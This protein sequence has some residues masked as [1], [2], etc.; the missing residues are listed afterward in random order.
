M[1]GTPEPG[2]PDLAEQLADQAAQKLTSDRSA[3]IQLLLAAHVVAPDRAVYRIELAQQLLGPAQSH[4]VLREQL[5]V[6]GPITYAAYNASG[7]FL[8]TSTTSKAYVWETHWFDGEWKTSGRPAREVDPVTAAAIGGASA[9]NMMVAT[10]SNRLATMW[11]LT[12]PRSVKP[13]GDLE[14]HAD[15]VAVTTTSEIAATVDGTTAT[16]WRAVTRPM[17]YS[18]LTY[19]R[20]VTAISFAPGHGL[21]LAAG[22]SDGGVT[23]HTIDQQRSTARSRTLQGG[24]GPVNTVAISADASTVLAVAE[25]GTVSV[26]DLTSKESSPSGGGR[27]EPGPHRAWVADKGGYAFIADAVHA[28]LWSVVGSTPTLLQDVTAFTNPSVPSMITMDGRYVA[29]IGAGGRNLVISDVSSITGILDDPVA[30]ACQVAAVNDAAWREMVLDPAVPNPCAG[31][32]VPT[33]S[34]GP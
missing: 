25:D 7:S 30:T 22:H 26:W 20:P 1:T 29:G 18:T 3:A 2:D 19:E 9:V 10:D 17:V 28:G 21:I 33:I 31:R 4:E 32:P 12:D 14:V 11:W 23:V 13:A 34:V 15:A 24:V 6:N 5:P 27:V 16:L 8:L